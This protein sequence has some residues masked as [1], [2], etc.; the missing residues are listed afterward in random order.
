M[1]Q[2]QALRLVFNMLPVSED[3]LQVGICQSPSR[4]FFE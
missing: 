2:S 1:E 4:I 3:V